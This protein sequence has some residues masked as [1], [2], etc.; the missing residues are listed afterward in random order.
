MR[1]LVYW[2]CFCA[3]GPL[4]WS[5]ELWKW[6]SSTEKQAHWTLSDPGSLGLA[7]KSVKVCPLPTF[8]TSVEDPPMLVTFCTSPCCA[9]KD[10]GMP[11]TKCQP[12]WN[13]ISAP[14]IAVLP[15]SSTTTITV[16][17]N[18]G[19]DGRRRSPWV[20]DSG[21]SVNEIAAAAEEDGNS[22]GS[23]QTTIC[24]ECETLDLQFQLER[25]FILRN[26]DHGIVRAFIQHR[27]ALPCD[28]QVDM[29]GDH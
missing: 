17:V 28:E 25:S 29:S 11:T 3:L 16:P 12:H 14:V 19:R 13:S 18:H 2:A 10:F 23:D 22:M 27:G 1:S 7:G 8:M 6:N 9:K 24:S 21:T 26:D 15:G 20:S 5:L 4:D